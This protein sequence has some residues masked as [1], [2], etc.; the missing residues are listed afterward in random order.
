M[1]Y[2]VRGYAMDMICFVFGGEWAENP[3]VVLG[4]GIENLLQ[5]INL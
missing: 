1:I 4:R 3:I 2:E 5:N